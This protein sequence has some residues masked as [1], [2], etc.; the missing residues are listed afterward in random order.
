VQAELLPALQLP[1]QQQGASAPVKNRQCRQNIPAGG[2]TP[3]SLMMG[4]V[5]LVN[6]DVE[7]N[8]NLPI[9]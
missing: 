4:K 1:L 3:S 8:Q 6:T 2:N 9:N 7:K 5:F